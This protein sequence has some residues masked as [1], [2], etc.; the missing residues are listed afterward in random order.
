MFLPEW[1][2]RRAETSPQVTLLVDRRSPRQARWKSRS[3]YGASMAT[4]R[5]ARTTR[6]PLPRSESPFGLATAL[7]AW[8]KGAPRRR[9]VEARRRCRGG[10]DHR[11]RSPVATGNRPQG[12]RAVREGGQGPDQFRRRNAQL[13][14]LLRGPSRPRF[15][16]PRATDAEG[17][18]TVEPEPVAVR[19]MVPAGPGARPRAGR[20]RPRRPVVRRRRA[21]RRPR[22]VGLADHGFPLAPEA[23]HRPGSRSRGWRGRS[24]SST[25][26][27]AP[28]RRGS[29]T[30]SCS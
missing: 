13:A 24:G 25:L 14:L 10:Q 21:S 29:R 17:R 1:F 30:C 12:I 22:D 20:P 16:E 11:S 5:R 9:R 2:R 7:S 19:R 18:R 8:Q 27:R 23:Q 28:R 4:R 6:S 3:R 15:R 26:P